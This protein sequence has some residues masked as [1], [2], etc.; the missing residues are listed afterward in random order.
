MP[1]R[2]RNG[3]RPH[4][5]PPWPQMGSDYAY[6]QTR[7]GAPTAGQLVQVQVLVACAWEVETVKPLPAA[8]AAAPSVQ[9]TPPERLKPGRPV[10]EPL[11]RY[12][13]VSTKYA[14]SAVAALRASASTRALKPRAR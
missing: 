2:K 5:R 8:Q 3:G 1:D 9:V 4:G 10:Q 6:E 14:S 7:L 12:E 13:S 11:V